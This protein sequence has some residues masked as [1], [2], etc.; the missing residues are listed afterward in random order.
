MTDWSALS[1]PTEYFSIANINDDEA[2]TFIKHLRE[3][4][5]YVDDR[6]RN[7]DALR[8]M[9]WGHFASGQ[10]LI[11]EIKGGRGYVGFV[12]IAPGYKANAIMKFW[13]TDIWGPSFIKQLRK[14]VDTVVEQFDLQ[15]IS[16][17]SPDPRIVKLARMVGFR[18]E[19]TREKDFQ[20]DGILYDNTLMGYVREQKKD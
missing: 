2:E 1:K 19:G 5:L 4:Y 16:T 17:E 13:G 8:S 18:V 6:L 9:L 3:D 14:L 7:D 20:W 10:C 11:Y 12:D 15:R